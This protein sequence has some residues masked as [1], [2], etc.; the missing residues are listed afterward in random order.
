MKKGEEKELGDV[1]KQKRGFVEK[2]VKERKRKKERK[3]VFQKSH[4][5]KHSREKPHGGREG[6]KTEGDSIF[7]NICAP[8]IKKINRN[9]A[10]SYSRAGNRKTIPCECYQRG[11]C[12]GEKGK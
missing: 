10:A 7:F 11:R 9:S 2:R 12:A 5:H 6:R 8:R 1:G 3:T 4:Q